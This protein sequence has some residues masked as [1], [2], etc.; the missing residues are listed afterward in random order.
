[1]QVSRSAHEGEG[2]VKI[3]VE[4]P[5]RVP[6]S[7]FT[8]RAHFVEGFRSEKCVIGGGMLKQT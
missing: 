4:R 3:R 1:M 2:A 6:A 7:V 8:D 5:E